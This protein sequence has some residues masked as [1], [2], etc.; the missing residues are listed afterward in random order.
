ME[1][2]CEVTWTRKRI[3]SEVIET[4]VL[5]TLGILMTVAG[6]T[7][8][9]CFD[10]PYEFW[11]VASFTALM[12]IALWKGNSVLADYISGKISWI[13]FPLKRLSIGLISTIAYTL[14]VMYFLGFIYH[15]IF[16]V[17]FASGAWYSVIITLV[18]SV[19]LHGR[20]FLINWKQS[21]VIAE[22]LKKENIAARYES[23][24][25]QVN[26]HF[27]FNSLNALSNL[28]YEDQDKAVKFIKQ[29]SEVYRYVLDTREKEIVPLAAELEFLK[30]YIFL[31]QIRFGEKLKISMDVNPDNWFIAP[32]ALQMLIENAIKHNVVSEAD[33]LNVV[34]LI[35]ENYLEVSNNI[36]KKSSMGEP[37]SGI[38]L[39]NIRKRY[40]FLTTR[41][42][43]IQQ[44]GKYFK[45][46]LPLINAL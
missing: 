16:L 1:K 39:E 5:A 38:G 10:N 45:V 22:Q 25:N 31:Q 40:E 18:I 21:A 19:V 15:M 34:I 36:Q 9:N 2:A 6:L 35:Q 11:I 41:P 32:L 37:S 23:L 24:K 12:W 26:P 17:N 14:G 30:S 4:L 29:L 28:V 33:P 20:A 44:D 7:C 3:L 46:K 43:V 42:V 8:R 13:D 27:L